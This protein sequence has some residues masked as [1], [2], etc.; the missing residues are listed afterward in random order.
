MKPCEKYFYDNYGEGY[1]HY[2]DCDD[3]NCEFANS[4]FVAF[5]VQCVGCCHPDRV[6]WSEE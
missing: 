5:G 4:Y 2:C 6:E 1:D 3:D